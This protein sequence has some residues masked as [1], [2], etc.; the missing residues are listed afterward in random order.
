[1]VINSADSQ[2]CAPCGACRQVITELAPDCHV[3]F[4]FGGDR[5]ERL[6]RDL[7]PFAFELER[8]DRPGA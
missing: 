8:P 6:A 3:S 2:P 5:I 7:L 4:L 1:L